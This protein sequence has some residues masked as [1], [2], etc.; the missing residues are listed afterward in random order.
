VSLLLLF[1]G[2]AVIVTPEP[3]PE[4]TPIPAVVPTSTVFRVA[5]VAFAWEK[6]FASV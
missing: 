5:A 4:P 1:G 6:P 3:E 2:V